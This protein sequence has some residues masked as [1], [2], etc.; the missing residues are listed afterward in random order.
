[1]NITAKLFSLSKPSL[2][3]QIIEFQDVSFQM[4][5]SASTVA[6]WGKSV[7]ENYANCKK[8]AINLVII[9]AQHMS[10][11]F[12]ENEFLEKQIFKVNGRPP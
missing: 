9:F 12:H 1:M 10:N 5:K 3:L 8:L 4:Y 7:S 11:I 6:F 2:Q